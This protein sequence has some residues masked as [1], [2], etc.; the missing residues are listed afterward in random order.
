MRGKKKQVVKECEK[1]KKDIGDEER[2]IDLGDEDV[3]VEGG[4]EQKVR[5][6]QIDGF[7]E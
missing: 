2:I 3:M 5:R 6:I 1:G 4:K 7:E